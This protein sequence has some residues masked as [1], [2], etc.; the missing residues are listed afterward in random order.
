MKYEI[1]PSEAFLF[2][3]RQWCYRQ[4]KTLVYL[5]PSREHEGFWDFQFVEVGTWDALQ[6]INPAKPWW[7]ANALKAKGVN[8]VLELWEPSDLSDFHASDESGAKPTPVQSGSI[9]YAVRSG[10]FIK[11]GTTTD[12]PNRMLG[13]QCGNPIALSIVATWPGDVR[14]EADAHRRFAHLRVRGEWFS[15]TADLLAFIEECAACKV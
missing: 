2:D 4:D 15:L 13:L 7:C 1:E 3:G 5:A 14:N 10:D 11:I 12:M 9:V 8:L 6:T